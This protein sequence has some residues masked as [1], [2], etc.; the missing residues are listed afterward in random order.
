MEGETMAAGASAPDGAAGRAVSARLTELVAIDTGI[1]EGSES[2]A[3]AVR[4]YPKAVGAIERIRARSVVRRAAIE[5][6]LAAVATGRPSKDGTGAGLPVAPSSASDALSR[7]AGA[8]VG[9]AFGR[10]VAYQ[11]ARLAYDAVTCDLVGSQ[12]GEIVAEFAEIRSALPH[13]VARE[14]RAA[15]MT[16]SCRCVICSLG[17]CGCVRATIATTEIAWTGDEPA[18]TSGLVLFGPPRAGSQLADAGLGDADRIVA[19]DGE[20]VGSNGELW[21]AVCRHAV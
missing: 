16:C 6:R 1:L 15:G 5:G 17:A 18:R 4:G 10:E 9:A 14:L 20:E 3:A 11:T 2:W 8:L 12:L 7:A 13:T 19:V 21:D